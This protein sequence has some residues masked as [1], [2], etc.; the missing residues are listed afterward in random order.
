LTAPLTPAHPPDCARQ[1]S[2]ERR[3]RLLGKFMEE[4]LVKLHKLLALR[5]AYDARVAEAEDAAEMAVAVEGNGEEGEDDEED[6]DGEDVTAEERVYLARMDAGLGTLHKLDLLL[7]YIV[8]ARSK[9]LKTAVLHGLYEAGRSLIDVAASIDEVAKIDASSGGSA[10]GSG[11]GAVR[12]DP[13]RDE[14]LA[15]MSGAVQ[16]LCAK[17]KQPLEA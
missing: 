11:S 10:S 6:Q 8:S 16:A 4:D 7:G 3:Q 1:L 2:D 15:Q 12:L 17:Y 13:V 9:P 14:R 5:Q